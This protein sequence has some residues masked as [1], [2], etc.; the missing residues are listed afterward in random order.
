MDKVQKLSSNEIQLYM[1]TQKVVNDG[2]F[3]SFSVH[4]SFVINSVS[5]LL[6]QIKYVEM[7]QTNQ[8]LIQE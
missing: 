5:T 2:M 1:H 7:V 3:L 6:T 4:H 8:N